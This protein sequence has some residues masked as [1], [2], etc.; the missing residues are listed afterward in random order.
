MPLNDYSIGDSGE[1]IATIQSDL[2]ML[3]Y[4]IDVDGQFGAQTQYA[5]RAFQAA[6]KMSPLSLNFDLTGVVGPA[7]LIEISKAIGEGWRAS[8]TAPAPVPAAQAGAVPVP[9]T[10]TGSPATGLVILVGLAL[11]AWFFMRKKA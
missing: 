1:D 9:A 3:G 11:L 7:T 4:S 10:S 6:R 2:N 8:A 5:V